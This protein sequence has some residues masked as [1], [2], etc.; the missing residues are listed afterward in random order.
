MRIDLGRRRLQLL[1]TTCPSWRHLFQVNG[2][3]H[4]V[5][6]PPASIVIGLKVTLLRHFSAS[7]V[8]FVTIY[9]STSQDLHHPLRNLMISESRWISTR[10]QMRMMSKRK[11]GKIFF[12]RR[13]RMTL[14]QIFDH[15]S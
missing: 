11:A 1:V 8:P 7:N 2:L 4:R 12:W 15:L 14:N 13:M 5:V 9:S 10:R 6:S 3:S